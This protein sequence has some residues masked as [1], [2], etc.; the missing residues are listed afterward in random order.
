MRAVH[1]SPD[2][3]LARRGYYI[4]KPDFTVDRTTDASVVLR[5]IE[6]YGETRDYITVFLGN[7]WQTETLLM[8]L[9]ELDE[10]DYRI[11]EIPGSN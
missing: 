9:A 6:E 3:L 10:K 11:G 8:Q 1:P 7:V 5:K 2:K 4:L